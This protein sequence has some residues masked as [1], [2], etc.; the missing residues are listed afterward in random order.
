M[1]HESIHTRYERSG[2]KVTPVRV[3]KQWVEFG[4]ERKFIPTR[5]T[6]VPF[7]K[8]SH[9]PDDW[10]SSKAPPM[11]R[12]ALVS[13]GLIR[14]EG[15]GQRYLKLDDPAT[16]LPHVYLKGPPWSDGDPYAFDTE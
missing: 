13:A 14:P 2:D 4:K 5:V 1:N 3:T 11:G 15:Y 6:T 16:H 9:G 12:D 10:Q 7:R 8:P